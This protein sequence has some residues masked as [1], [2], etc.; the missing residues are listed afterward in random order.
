M[1]LQY[2]FVFG[3]VDIIFGFIPHKRTLGNSDFVRRELNKLTNP[4]ILNC[5]SFKIKSDR[6][7]SHDKDVF[8]D[9][10][11]GNYYDPLLS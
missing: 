9:Y 5:E 6:D 3:F 2:D 1:V 8:L 10:F 7:S 4:I 11:H